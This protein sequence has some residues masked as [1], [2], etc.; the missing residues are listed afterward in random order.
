MNYYRNLE[1]KMQPSVLVP[2]ANG[3]E[4]IETMSIVDILRRAGVEVMLASIG[5]KHVVGAHDVELVAQAKLA[6]IDGNKYD[7]VVLPGGMPGADNLRQSEEVRKIVHQFDNK[8]KPI[9]AICA[10]PWA[11]SDMGALKDNYT[12]Y[13]SFERR[14][15]KGEYHSDKSVVQDQNIITATGPATAMEFALEIVKLLRGEEV[16][17]QVKSG[18]LYKKG[19]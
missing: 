3:F 13:P 4:E 6:D 11:L 1:E 9:G 7:M 17:R 12:C 19:S 2:L 16:Y 18:L 14:I 10:A 8:N 5:E 15:S